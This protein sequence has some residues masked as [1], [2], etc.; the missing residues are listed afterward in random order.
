MLAPILP[1]HRPRLIAFKEQTEMTSIDTSKGL[2]ARLGGWSARHKKSVLLGWFVFVAL[3]M[4]VSTFLPANKLTEA[5]QFTGE[6]GR[7]EKTLESSFPKPAAEM[8]LIHSSTLTTDDPAFKRAISQATAGFVGLPV[9]KDLKAPG[10]RSSTGLV[11]ND[12]H[13]AMI[14]FAIKGDADTASDR[15]APVVAAIKIARSANPSVQIEEFGDATSGAAIDKMVQD[16]LSKAETMSLPVTLLILILAFGAIVAA[17]VPVL[18]AISAVLATIGLVSIPSQIFPIDEN[19]SIVITLIGMAVGVDYSLFYLKRQREERAAGHDELTAV[20]IASATSGRAILVSGFTVMVAMAGQFLTGDKASTSFAVGTILVVAIAMLGSLTALPAALALLGRHVDKGRIRIPFR[21]RKPARRDSRV[22]G[23]VLTRV[24]RRPVAA[25]VLSTALLLAI[26]S[27]VMHFKVHNTGI[28]DLPPGLPGM[29]TLKHLEKAFPNS[30][31]PAIVVIKADDTRDPAVQSAMSDLREQAIR[32]GAAHQPITVTN[33]SKHTVTVLSMPL[34]GN[35]SNQASKQA[36]TTLR[37]RLIPSS[38]GSLG[39]VS[40]DVSGQTAIDRDQSTMLARNTPLVFGFVLTLAFLLL[41][42]T[43]RSIV[44]PIKAIILNLLSVAAAYGVLV[45]VFQDGHGAS[46][47]GF[48]PTGGVA[49]WLPLF[50]FVILFGLSMDYHV[51][52]LSRVKELVDR[53]MS[54]EDAVSEGIKSTAGTVTSA[55]LVMVGVF[56]IFIT[57]SIVDLKEFGVGLAAAILIDATIIR[58]VLLPASMKLLG[59]WNWYLPRPLHWLPRFHV[60]LSQ[61][62]VQT[63][64]D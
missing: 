34:A 57:L 31:M 36:L 52:I 28:N 14:Q 47:L 10:Y 45:A 32:S 23:A 48:T 8:V 15:I 62:E 49:P 44:I 41:M 13:T 29:T 61:L 12:R 46:L 33:D 60:E 7:A 43:F 20:G 11:S 16:D 4:L 17:G 26:A 1:G 39:N 30:D 58:G 27:P 59:D 40:V 5:D 56:S 24:L 53:G 9:V 19:A 50:L 37:D 22:W 64:G 18:L 55:A 35:G 38:F 3:A 25:A 21:R 2:A 63:S 51:F 54:T 42:V 6:S